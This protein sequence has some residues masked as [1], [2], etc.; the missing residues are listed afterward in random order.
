[1]VEKKFVKETFK[2]R[3]YEINRNSDRV[4][5]EWSKI[6]NDFRDSTYIL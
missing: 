5:T 3:S 6:L 2:G 1:M 4:F